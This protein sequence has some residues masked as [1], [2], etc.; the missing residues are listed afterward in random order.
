MEKRGIFM[1][2]LLIVEDEK[3][4]RE[5]L[6]RHIDWNGIGVDPV[7]AVAGG[8]EALLAVDEIHPDILLSDI[9]MPHMTG[10]ELASIIRKKFPRCKIIFLSGY[11]D[12][13]YLMSAIELKAVNYIE[14]PIDLTEIRNAVAKA[15][16]QLESE[17]KDELIHSGFQ[18]TLPIIHEE[19]VSALISPD[20]NWEKF[21]QDFIPLYFTWSKV[22][23]YSV[24]CIRPGR[25]LTNDSEAK[26]FLACILKAL[27]K[28]PGL[29]SD[30]YL[31][32]MMSPKEAVLICR[33]LLSPAI[34][35]VFKEL[36]AA[37]TENSLPEASFGI[38]TP[39]LSLT[40][41][42]ELYHA[43]SRSTEY[44]S[45]YSEKYGI[46]DLTV[47]LHAKEAPKNL[48]SSKELTLSGAETL[49]DTLS[50]EK[51]TDI[52]FIRGELY[53]IYMMAIEKSWDE[54]VV[55]WDEF[56]M[57]SFEEYR[58]LICYEVNTI[59]LLGSD[60]Y[61]IKIKNAVHY[62]L[63][64]YSDA[65]LSIKVI[66]DHVNLSQNYLSTLFRKQT[67]TTIND[68][69]LNIRTEKACRLLSGTDL[70]LYEIA[71]KIGLSDANYLS[72]VFKKRYG[73][74]PTLYR[75]TVQ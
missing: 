25:K 73:V 56:E 23:N 27:E 18:K 35:S 71:E 37:F 75:K 36:N 67:G 5:G 3:R 17:L 6:C 53:K 46:F 10:I 21:S 63:W 66:A 58:E 52:P 19:I 16:V 43:V 47:P 38:S 8:M 26:K 29:T 34:S 20:L 2:H 50:R 28:V 15:V 74:T 45:F 65:D 7:T 24:S 44:E 39:C 64:N 51:Y 54:K 13:E 68:F 41:I 9:R 31:C 1:F 48:F 61:D 72:T 11:T 22:G 59:Q 30:D 60:I 42:S 49:F 57:F 69:I 55:S 62:I 40:G 4:T 32:T 14:K 12:K 70:K 33:N